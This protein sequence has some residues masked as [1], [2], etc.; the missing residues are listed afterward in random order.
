MAGL[1]CAA[2]LVESVNENSTLLGDQWR[3]GFPD[4]PM[5]SDRMRPNFAVLLAL[6]WVLAAAWLLVQ[7][8]TPAG[9]AIPDP[10]DAMRLVQVREFLA[11]KGWF[12]LAEPRVNPPHGYLTHWSRLI[13][14]GLASLFMLA[15]VFF[16]VSTAEQVMIEVWP[17]LWLLPAMGGVAAIAWRFGGRDAALVGLVLAVFG[18]PAFQHFQPGR[19]DHHNVQIALAILT[20]AAA[21]WSDRVAWASIATGF[22]SALAM[23]IGLESLPWIVLAGAAI[24]LRFVFDVEGAQ[25]LRDYGLSLAAGTLAAFF[26]IVNPALWFVSVCDALAVNY[27]VPVIAAGILLAASASFAKSSRAKRFVAV[28]ICGLIASATFVG[29][30]PGCLRGPFAMVDSTVL[31]NWLAQVE[32]MSPLTSVLG[33][34]PLTGAWVSAFPAVALIAAVLLL[35]TP[36]WRDFAFLLASVALLLAV[37]LTFATV[38]T[39]SYAMWFA[40]PLAAVGAVHFNSYFKLSRPLS[41]MTAFALTPVVVSAVAITFLQ[42]VFS[43]PASASVA[44]QVCFDKKNYAGLAQLPPGVIATDVDFGPLVLA[45]T[46]HRVVAAPYHRL[47]G[48]ILRAQRALGSPPDAARGVLREARADYVVLC[49]KAKPSGLQGAA[50]TEGL[51]AKLVAGEVPG[52]LTPVTT[53]ENDVFVVYRVTP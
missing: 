47:S 43:S 8:W 22:L 6:A 42:T 11:G 48:G 1:L 53:R 24:A 51:W 3:S 14:L 25:A 9:T 46:P 2:A 49:G 18:L 26:V 27:A 19:I 12:D 16:D 31:Q 38:K 10:D 7:F 52:W 4:T 41:I 17:V 29:I 30:E 37:A 36:L 13:D 33:A 32:E 35:R 40:M 50:L 5:V 23:A 39:Y 28:G 15:R 34:M 45:L 20:I 21:A 44:R